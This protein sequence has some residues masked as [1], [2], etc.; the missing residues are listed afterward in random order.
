[1]TSVY[2]VPHFNHYTWSVPLTALTWCPPGFHALYTLFELTKTILGLSYTRRTQSQT[3]IL[4]VTTPLCPDYHLVAC[5]GFAGFAASA[6]RSFRPS[7]LPCSARLGSSTSD[8]PALNN[9]P[10]TPPDPKPDS[11]PHA[12]PFPTPSNHQLNFPLQTAPSP[13]PPE[14]NPDPRH[15][16]ALT[17]RS[18]RH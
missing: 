8:R 14:H 3:E 12:A 17:P 10:P 16:C 1:M 2:T 9:A 6:S 13:T 7:P 15:T 18:N 5:S 4:T 11:P